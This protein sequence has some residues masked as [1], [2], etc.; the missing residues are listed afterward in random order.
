MLVNEHLTGL[1]CTFIEMHNT[2]YT[3]TP[4]DKVKCLDILMST[5]PMA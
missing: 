5:V 3:V 4:G 2:V 1:R